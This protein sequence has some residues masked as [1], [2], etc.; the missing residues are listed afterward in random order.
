M[1]NTYIIIIII[2]FFIIV[3]ITGILLFIYYNKMNNINKPT[4]NNEK[5]EIYCS[6]NKEQFNYENTDDDI[7]L[8]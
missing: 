6:D 5:K 7:I 4:I 2:I 3:L 8:F 1:K